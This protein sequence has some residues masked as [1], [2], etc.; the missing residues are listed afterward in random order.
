MT[1]LVGGIAG[2]SMVRQVLFEENEPLMGSKKE[3]HQA[4]LLEHLA[5]PPSIILAQFLVSNH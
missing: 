1:Y 5:L 2:G 4:N 3:V